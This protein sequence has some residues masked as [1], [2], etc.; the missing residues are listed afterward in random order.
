MIK[1]KN[2]IIKEEVD[3]KELKNTLKDAIEGATQLSKALGNIITIFVRAH[4]NDARAVHEDPLFK[5]VNKIINIKG[6]IN[7]I[8]VWK[9]HFAKLERKL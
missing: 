2:M 9:K 5:V 3:R 8:Y 1:L 4:K 6:K 7:K